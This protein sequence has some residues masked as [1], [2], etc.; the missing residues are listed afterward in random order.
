M[1]I[2]TTTKT[3]TSTSLN[4]DENIYIYSY[5]N[6]IWIIIEEKK[7]IKIINKI[8]F[9]KAPLYIKINQLNLYI[10]I[11]LDTLICKFIKRL[12]IYTYI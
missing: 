7:C 10:D 4:N 6:M 5:Y 1:K 11:L 9:S 12:Y 3:T 2:K 8:L